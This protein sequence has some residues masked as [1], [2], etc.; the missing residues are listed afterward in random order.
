[1]EKPEFVTIGNREMGFPVDL[2][3]TSKS[4]S[5][6]PDGTVNRFATHVT[7]SKKGRSIRPSLRFPLASNT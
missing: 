1:M 7:G 5:N 6:L 4:P 2:T 3:Q